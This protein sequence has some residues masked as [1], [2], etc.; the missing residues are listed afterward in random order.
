[1]AQEADDLAQAVTDG[2]IVDWRAVHQDLAGRQAAVARSL[3]HLSRR[4][5]VTR[6]PVPQSR[7]LPLSLEF[8][9]VASV[10]ACLASAPGFA[11]RSQW[12]GQDMILAGVT[13]LFAAAAVYLDVGGI[14]RRARALAAC[15]WATAASFAARGIGYA[16]AEWPHLTTLHLVHASRPEVFFGAALWQFAGDFP[17]VTRFSYVDRL[18]VVGRRVATLLAVALYVGSLAPALWPGWQGARLVGALQRGQD[19]SGTLFWI[20]VFGSALG[21][22]VTL[23]RRARDAP[24]PERAR[25]RVFLFSVALAFAPVIMV[26]LVLLL[27]PASLRVAQSPR[28]FFWVGLLVYPPIVILP[29]AT[30]YAVVADDVL[31]VRVAVQQG[32]RYLLARW[33]LVWGA[34]VPLGLLAMHLFR[35]A[36]MPLAA[37][38]AVQPAQTLL[39]ASGAGATVLALR[40]VLLTALDKWALGGT[41]Q[42]SEALAFMAERLKEDRTPL[43]VATTCAELAE[44]AFQA[45]ARVF[46]AIGGRLVPTK[47]PGEPL[48]S[49]STVMALV[50]G[51][52][53]ACLVSASTRRSYYNLLTERD[54]AWV[55]R[56]GVELLIPLWSARA[57]RPY[58]LVALGARRNALRYSDD[59]LRLVR[60][61]AASAGLAYDALRAADEHRAPESRGVEELA[62]Q[63]ST[64]GLVSRWSPGSETCSCGGT[65]MPAALPQR[66]LDRFEVQS[67]LGAGGM[68]I[69]YLAADKNLG[70]LVALK[71]L[72]RLS[73][74][75]ALRLE[76][77]AR[78]MANLRVEDVAVLYDVAR[79]QDTPI[80]AM[81]YLSG[82]TL[83]RRLAQGP[84]ATADVVGLTR[85]ISQSLRHL[86]GLGQYH[87][88]LKPSNIG[89]S[90]EGAPKLLD[91]GLA[92]ALAL[93]DGAGHERSGAP[94][95]LPGGT[96]AY[97]SPEV[98]GGEPGD[99]RLDLWALGVVLCECLSG[100]HPC[101]KGGSDRELRR[102]IRDATA[103]LRRSRPSWLID[104]LDDM[105]NADPRVRPDSAGEVERRLSVAT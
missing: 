58:G 20:I 81:E 75:A 29:F 68:G 35:H 11:S 63:C 43:E 104:L 105:L 53:D 72:P 25:V 65:W 4:S 62:A 82:G 60:T 96:W 91:F 59:D 99:H 37:S 89:F 2:D 97:M 101:P 76:S 38:L 41:T 73:E 42:A 67:W 54:R 49:P 80:L 51:T 7:R 26:V 71:T 9:R 18:C 52:R 66:L 78:A 64:C 1:M 19:G 6:R 57:G 55:D 45:E 34:A 27:S 40:R 92:R 15:Y 98:R 23:G 33:V 84:L 69:V 90:A 16:V 3:E 17:Q 86:H 8:A 103:Q 28:G 13:A 87:G 44:R 94:T 48:E 79:W 93:K 22:L 61:A 83:A 102:G 77:E 12:T 31:G 24:G 46:V 32:V 88:D 21:A 70:R 5:S 100:T 56:A 10:V 30:M 50:E 14:D 39:W 85:R 74:D 47:G 36:N 95:A